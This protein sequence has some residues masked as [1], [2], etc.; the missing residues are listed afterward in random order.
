MKH[1]LRWL[2]LSACLSAT[3]SLAVTGGEMAPEISTDTWL[4]SEPLTLRAL[5]G[6]VVLVEFW[7]FECYNCRNVEPYVKEWYARFRERG[8][9]VVAVH[10]PEFAHEHDIE[11]VRRYL[12]R[13]AIDY[14]V[15]IDNDF[16]I[17]KR[18]ANRYWPAMYFV[19]K[20]GAVRHVQIGEG[21]Y[22]RSA[23]MIESL[24]AESAEPR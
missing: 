5:R 17:W 13:R 23:A 22:R 4:N 6:R 21:G 12:K 1:S 20:R 8:F 16:A 19:D 11:N 3:S 14:P 2:A 10:S 9:T 18:Y 15:A 24:L 7:T